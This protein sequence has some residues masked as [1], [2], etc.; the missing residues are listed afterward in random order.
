MWCG[1]LQY[2][3]T[4]NAREDLKPFLSLS[5][6]YK[7]LNLL[8]LLTDASNEPRNSKKTFTNPYNHPVIKFINSTTKNHNPGTDK[9]R[10]KLFQTFYLQSSTHW[11]PQFIIQLSVKSFS[12]STKYLKQ[13]LLLPLSIHFFFF[14][15]LSFKFHA[16]S[17]KNCL[18]VRAKEINFLRRWHIAPSLTHMQ[19][20]C[21]I[22]P[23]LEIHRLHSLVWDCVNVLPRFV[24]HW[25]KK[26]Y[27][28]SFTSP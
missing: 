5:V 3:E 12:S 16:L 28:F 10:N 17:E 1:L 25:Q 24:P 26:Y 14:T 22:F 19:T 11:G 7:F 8:F 4:S 23:G 21:R 18:D 6:V 13:L 15:G 9:K 27:K 20:A 2:Q